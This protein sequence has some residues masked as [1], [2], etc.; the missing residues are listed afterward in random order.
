MA[1][2]RERDR[3]AILDALAGGVTPRQGIQHI[4]VGRLAETNA[5]IKDIDAITDGRASARIID[6]SYGSGKLLPL[7]MPV[8][9]DHG[10]VQNGDIEIGDKV[11]T[12]NGHLSK[13]TGIYP[14]SDVETYELHLADD[15]VVEAGP[16]HLWIVV[17][18][19]TGDESVLTT[20]AIKAKPL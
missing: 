7:D 17:D 11:Y 13:V 20:S 4:Q 14:E 8:L 19:E 15:R 12:R 5:I 6:A 9:T 3:N 10:W 1:K 16:D 2:I 18:T